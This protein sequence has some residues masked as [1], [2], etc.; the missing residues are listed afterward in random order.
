LHAVTLVLP[1]RLSVVVLVFVTALPLGWAHN[2]SGTYPV[3]DANDKPSG[4]YV[5]SAGVYAASILANT[6]TEVSLAG[7]RVCDLEVT[8]GSA[9]QPMDESMVDGGVGGTAP[10]GT[11]DD[12]GYGHVQDSPIQLEWSSRP[13]AGRL[14][15][16]RQCREQAAAEADA[17]IGF[18]ATA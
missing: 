1:L 17:L 2:D 15:A 5:G 6:K 18:Q 10:D 12:G 14:A 13:K 16:L 7:S 11:W 9:P 8:D 3:T 4:F